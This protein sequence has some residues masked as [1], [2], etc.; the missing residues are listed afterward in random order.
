MS[1]VTRLPDPLGEALALLFIAFPSGVTDAIKMVYLGELRRL[2]FPPA[3]V[4]EA[5][6]RIL[7]SR[8]QRTV[9][10]LA[11]IIA[12][13]RDAQRDHAQESGGEKTYSLE[14]AQDL[15]RRRLTLIN[16]RASKKIPVTDENIDLHVAQME[17]EGIIKVADLR[18]VN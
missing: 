17:R 7:H 18:V 16:R 3:V 8:E 1:N 14:E 5:A 11:V 13:C 12:A 15:A 6:Q 9:P 4:K 2:G 10:P